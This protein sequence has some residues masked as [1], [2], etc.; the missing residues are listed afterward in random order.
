MERSFNYS[1]FPFYIRIYINLKEMK[2]AVRVLSL[3]V[4][5]GVALFYVS[6]DNS[7][8]PGKSDQDTQIEKLN[9]SWTVSSNDDVTLDGGSTGEDYTGF[10][11]DIDGAAGSNV[12]SYTTTGRPETSAWPAN[13]TLAFGTNVSQDLLRDNTLGITYSVTDTEL[14]ME[15]NYSGDPF[16]AR[17]KNVQGAWRFTFAKQ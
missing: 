7:D 8:S 15:F 12:I 10:T 11:L 1:E 16:T 9:G 14:I 13:G 4:L 6:C 3:V 17:S 5:A 2:L